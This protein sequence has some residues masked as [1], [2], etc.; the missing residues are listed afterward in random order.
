MENQHRLIRTYRELTEAE[1][2]TINDSKILEAQVLQLQK[3]IL[4]KAKED[5]ARAKNRLS[6]TADAQSLH[7]EI[8]RAEESI[9]AAAIAKTNLQTGFMWMVQAAARPEEP[10]LG[11]DG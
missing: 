10:R 2:G 9:R 3:R 1:I 7:A 5:L 8:R 6:S 4:E 11:E